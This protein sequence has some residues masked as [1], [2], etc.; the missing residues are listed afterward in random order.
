M[1]G[2]SLLSLFFGTPAPKTDTLSYHL[3]DDFLSAAELNFFRV[4]QAVVGQHALIMSKVNLKD[5]F[6]VSRS[7][8]SAYQR[9]I[10]KIDR[11]HV[12]FLLCDP[13]SVKP[14][15]ALELDDKSHQRADRQSRDLFVED[16]FAG[17]GLPLVRVTVRRSYSRAELVNLLAPYFANR[18]PDYAMP[19]AEPSTTTPICPKCGGEMVL[20]TVKKGENAGKQFWGCANYPQCRSVLA[21]E[22]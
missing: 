3:R 9:A 21:Y 1:L 22:G 10:N 12:D 8:Y 14:I 2:C 6:W 7:D 13:Q 11:K 18:S 17:A 16:V 4:L 15:V 20:R 5:L 19:T